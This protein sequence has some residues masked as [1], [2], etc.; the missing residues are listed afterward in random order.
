MPVNE[1]GI[2]GFG[3]FGGW[4]QFCAQPLGQRDGA[5][6]FGCDIAD[7]RVPFEHGPGVSDAGLCG[8]AC[9]AFALIGGVKEDPADFAF[10]P[11]ARIPMADDPD[12][13]IV[14]LFGHGKH[15]EAVRDPM[16]DLCAKE[17][18]GLPFGHWPAGIL[19]PFGGI[20]RDERLGVLGLWRAQDQTVGCE[21]G[22]VEVI[23][24]AGTCVGKAKTSRVTPSGNVSRRARVPPSRIASL[25]AGT[26]SSR[27]CVSTEVQ[28]RVS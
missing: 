8:L 25:R 28:P 7:D 1:A 27:I 9:D 26:F 21:D 6:V 11:G 2:C 17:V 20:E 10:R 14:A 12:G 15:P 24:H 19:R 16:P 3:L 18:P 22:G 5:V 13:R 4:V 23:A